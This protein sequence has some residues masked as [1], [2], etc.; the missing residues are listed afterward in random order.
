MVILSH[1]TISNPHDIE[2]IPLTFLI[3]KD[4]TDPSFAEFLSYANFDSTSS[5]QNYWIIK[6]G[7]N[8][9]RGSGIQVCDSIEQLKSYISSSKRKSYII[10]K[11]ITNPLLIDGRKFD[12]RC[13]ALLT[14]I[15]G[16]KKAYFY[17]GGY[18]RTSSKEYELDDINDKLVHLTND[19]V[20]K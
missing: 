18:L 2:N 16:R 11:Y 20:Q 15:N 5:D 7:E 6:P 13:Y 17:Q 8:S 12:I 9:N 3:K 19:A 4:H 10:Q 1:F 14:S